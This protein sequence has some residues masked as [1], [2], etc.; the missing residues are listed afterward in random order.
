M[1]LGFHGSNMFGWFF[2]HHPTRGLTWWFSHF[3][4]LM[5]RVTWEHRETLNATLNL[6]VFSLI[7]CF[8]SASHVS[9]L[10]GRFFEPKIWLLH[11]WPKAT[12]QVVVESMRSL[13]A[14]Y[15]ALP[16]R[17]G[18][19]VFFWVDWL[20]WAQ[21]GLGCWGSR[22][23]R[24]PK[25]HIW[26]EQIFIYWSQVECAFRKFHEVRLVDFESRSLFINI[27]MKEVFQRK[28]ADK[29]KLLLISIHFTP[30]KRQSSCLNKWYVDYVKSINEM[31]VDC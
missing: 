27:S 10:E 1:T 25:T 9:L 8:L 7:C 6:L 21:K 11:L 5:I 18:I 31:F 15:A 4:E 29:K 22:F 2:E 3:F 17:P 14:T 24:G 19:L 26:A 28:K 12:T 20:P 23:F 13:E 30:K 16:N